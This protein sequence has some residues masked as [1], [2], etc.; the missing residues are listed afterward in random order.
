MLSF[1]PNVFVR[2]DTM[3]GVCE[4]L[5]ED[6]R[7]NPQYLRMLLGVSLIWNPAV[8]VGAYVALGIII[9]VSRWL[10]PNPRFVVSGLPTAVT[11]AAAPK[12]AGEHDQPEVE[13]EAA[14]AMLPLAA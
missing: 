8:V 3:F 14:P 5:G 12:A 13:A 11:A 1:Q 2:H 6:F 7:F 4:A 10:S 9:A